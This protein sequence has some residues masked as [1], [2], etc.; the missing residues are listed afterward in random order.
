MIQAP[1]PDGTPSVPLI[2]LPDLPATPPPASHVRGATRRDPRLEDLLVRTAGVRAARVETTETGEIAD[3]QVVADGTLPAAQQARQVRSALIASLGVG[4]GLDRISLIAPEPETGG[5]EGRRPRAPEPRPR[6]KSLASQQDGGFKVTILAE[7]E[8]NGKAVRGLSRDAD[9]DQGRIAAAARATLS[10]LEKL[11]GGRVALSL[12]ALD[13]VRAFQRVIVV[14]SVRVLGDSLRGELVGCA[15]VTDDPRRAAALA[16][17]A[18]VNRVVPRVLA[19]TAGAD[20]ERAGHRD[21]T[22][23]AYAED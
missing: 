2:V 11:G 13:F 20:A 3:V 14:A 15:R 12:E 19:S 18:A 16:A 9:T 21:R 4:V 8:W 5:S 6:L 17:L 23:P 22:P 1:P 10:A 7:L